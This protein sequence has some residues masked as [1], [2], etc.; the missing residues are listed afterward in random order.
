MEKK[1]LCLSLGG[2]RKRKILLVMKLCISLL[3]CFTLGL[4]ASTLAQQKRVNLDLKQ[5]PI[6]V[7]F[8]EIQ[9]QTNLSFVFNTEQTA[10]LGEVSVRAIDETVENV[11]R[12]VLMNTGMLFEFDGTLIIVRPDEPQKK[13]VTKIN[14]TGT[15][16]DE[17]GEFLPGV[18]I[19]LKGSQLG[20]VT[21][22]DGKF[23]FELPKQDSLV[24]VFS[25]IGYKQQE[26]KVNSEN[27][28]PLSIVLKEEVTEVGEVVVT[29]YFER[30]KDSYTGAGNNLFRR[31]IETNIYG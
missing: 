24:L 31:R 12:K 17:N 19:L 1:R 16:K 3:L 30:R 18:T 11:L 22:V 28:Q 5:V 20:T 2:H 23:N 13:E 15:V 9:K 25:F 8:D 7:L 4:S 27:L 29:G 21:D 10:K 26:I 6:K 14:V